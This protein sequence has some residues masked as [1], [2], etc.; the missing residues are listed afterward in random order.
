MMF[1][2]H[3]ISP[4]LSLQLDAVRAGAAFYVVV[5]HLAQAWGFDQG[6][7]LV[8]RFGQEAVLLFFL[9]SGFVIFANE[10]DR[11]VHPM[12][13]YLRRIRRIYPPLIVAMLVSLCVALWN[14]RQLASADWISALATLAGLQD[15]A[16]LKP[17]VIANPFLG[18]TPL[19]SLS[20]ELF[21]YLVFPP[22][23]R[24]WIAK[25]VVTEH[26]I[27]LACCLLYAAFAFAPNHFALV[28]SYFLVWWSGAM[29]A[30]AYMSGARNFLVMK[31]TLVWL[32]ALC[33]VALAVVI[34]QGYR[35]LGVH[36][37]LELRHFLFG[38][39]VI[40]A[41]FSP[42]GRLIARRTQ[43]VARYLAMLAG[44]SYGIYVLHYPLL[45]H[46]DVARNPI[47]F[48]LAFA[49]LLALSYLVEIR[50]PQLLPK[51][52]KT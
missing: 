20:Y 35:G 37:F 8:F 24:A 3:R 28:G 44:V 26:L 46:L 36:P 42:F 34:Q 43:N 27:G 15:V 11:A 33:G 48:A 21:F 51:A 18:N 2:M 32:M 50:L 7:G 39:V 22:I 13:Y 29:V 49:G 17:G 10:R 16:A 45:I 5:H 14:G 40:V 1:A 31:R 12:G 47:G 23:L 4:T 30:N 41:A 52:P 9:L 19:W 25:P 6:A 38:M